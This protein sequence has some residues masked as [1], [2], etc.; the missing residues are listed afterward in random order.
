[1]S[2]MRVSSESA[3]DFARGLVLSL[4]GSKFEVERQT[5]IPINAVHGVRNFV[6]HVGL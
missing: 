6:A 3:D 2:L 1:M 5:V 4:F